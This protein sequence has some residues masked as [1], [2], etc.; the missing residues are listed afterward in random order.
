[1]YINDA[2][3]AS[4]TCL[5]ISGFSDEITCEIILSQNSLGKH[6]LIVKNGFDSRSFP[7]GVLSF[8]IS[9]I[10]N[11]KNT[12]ETGSFTLEVFD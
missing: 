2:N 6:Y 9:E 4:S 1:M 5:K 8:N 12:E 10:R 11:P 3:I 7:G